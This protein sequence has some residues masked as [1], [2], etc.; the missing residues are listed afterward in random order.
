[1]NFL[2][3]S[4]FVAAALFVQINLAMAEPAADLPLKGEPDQVEQ[5]PAV[6]EV[7]G[8]PE[9]GEDEKESP[10]TWFGM[11]YELRNYRHSSPD[12]APDVSSDDPA[13]TSGGKQ[14]NK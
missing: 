14:R 13:S 8:D 7:W 10:W 5:Q 6:P 4:I 12:V 1:M 11:G 2:R 9:A 3:L